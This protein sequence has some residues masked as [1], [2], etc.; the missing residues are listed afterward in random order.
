MQASRNMTRVEVFEQIFLVFLGLGTLVGIVVVAYTLYNAYKYRDTGDAAGDE[1]LPSVGE[2]PTGGKG[3]K[4]LFLSFGISAIIVISLVIWTYAMLLYV[5][6][7]GTANDAQQEALEG[8]VQV[9]GESFAWFFTYDNGI[10][11]TGTLRVPANERIWLQVTGGDVWHAF[12]IPDQRVKADA[13]PGEY[14]KTWFEAEQPGQTHEIKC[15]EL[16]GEF[17]T[18]M[19]GTVQV[20]EPQAFEQWMNEQLTMSITV[21]RGEGEN[22]TRVTEGFEMTLEHREQDIQR[23]YTADDF[24][25]GSITINDLEQGGPYNVTITPTDGQFEPTT[26]QIEMTGPVDETVTVG[27][28]SESGNSTD[29]NTNGSSNDGGGH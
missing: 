7:P 20:M 26:K 11:S 1:N 19:T 3:G 9:V 24:E 25:N 12:G 17:H 15:F 5:E 18:S 29:S 21:A 13:I 14:D 4:K 8:P 2:L 23:T 10:E 6:D 16:C 27:S 22:Q 28:G